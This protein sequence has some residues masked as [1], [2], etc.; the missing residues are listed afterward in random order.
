MSLCTRRKTNVNTVIL[1]HENITRFFR[2][3]PRIEPELETHWIVACV[4]FSSPALERSTYEQQQTNQS[5]FDEVRQPCTLRRRRNGNCTAKTSHYGSPENAGLEFDGRA[6][7]VI[8]RLHD[9]TN[10]KQTIRAHVVHVFFA[11][12]C[13]MFASSCKQCFWVRKTQIRT[14]VLTYGALQMQTTYLLTYLNDSS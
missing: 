11:Y 8:P 6:M 2:V 4:E 7:C 1:L 5:Q 13:L 14:F 3:D 9:E 10:M 12:V